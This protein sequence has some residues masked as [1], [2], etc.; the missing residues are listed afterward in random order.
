M[1]T[2]Y[3]P[4]EQLVKLAKSAVIPY[5]P[6]QQL[7]FGLTLIRVTRGF[8]NGLGEWDAKPVKTWEIF[9]KHLKVHKIN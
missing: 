3:R 8:E 6:E 5:S 9:K 7:E 4:I 1:V 2:F